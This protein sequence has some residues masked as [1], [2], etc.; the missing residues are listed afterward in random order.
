MLEVFKE[1]LASLPGDVRSRIEYIECDMSNFSFSKRFDLIIAPFRA[2]QA[3]TEEKDINSCLKCVHEHLSENG[4]FIVNVFRPYKVLDESWC[5]PETLQWEIVDQNTGTKIT[6]KH[7]GAKIDVEK[8]II[9]PNFAYEISD[10]S[11]SYERIEEKLS[12]KYY[13]YQ[14]LHF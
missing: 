4:C 10:D 13:Y 8:Q 14:Q 6:K 5:Y 11:G 3:L 1:K 9:Y 7:W 12:L 2:F